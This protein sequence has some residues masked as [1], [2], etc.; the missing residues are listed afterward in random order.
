MN[1]RKNN[2]F[3]FPDRSAEQ[4][5]YVEAYMKAAGMF[6]DFN[7]ADQDPVFTQT[8]ELD[9]TTVVPS[10]SGP[11]RPQDRVSQ[12]DLK[13][14]FKQCLSNKV[15][16]FN[17]WRIAKCYVNKLNIVRILA[18]C[19]GWLSRLWYRRRKIEL[20]RFFPVRR[21]NLYS[22][23]RLRSNSSHYILY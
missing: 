15:L 4:I 2:L 13:L 17:F 10:L 7:N 21:F 1:S 16:I 23:T 18:L 11:K 8:Y 14:E 6:R 3:S 5:A 12:S 19:L 20:E 9:L 22:K